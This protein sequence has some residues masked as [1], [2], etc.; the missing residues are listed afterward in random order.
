M[1]MVMSIKWEA[2]AARTAHF[3]GRLGELLQL[4]KNL[5][6]VRLLAQLIDF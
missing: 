5:T 2:R 6:I 3:K 1:S 4:S